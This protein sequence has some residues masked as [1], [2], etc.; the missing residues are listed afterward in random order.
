MT[1]EIP[2]FE[3]DS[4]EEKMKTWERERKGMLSDLAGKREEIRLLKEEVAEIRDA[5]T[6]AANEGDGETPQDRV[7]RLAQDP[8][9]YIDERINQFRETE[10]KPLRSELE[11]MKIDRAIERGL[12]WVAKQEKK[13]YEDVA[14]SDLEL[15][16][17][18]ITQNMKERGIVPTN[19]EEGTKEA[20]RLYLKEKE[21]KEN[22]EKERSEKIEG[23]KTESVVPP[24]RSGSHRWT[25][26]EVAAM[27]AE[28]FTKNEA[29]IRKAAA[30][31]K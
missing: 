7:N 16:L 10:V 15:D 20:Y 13:D 5:I 31:W 30:T 11:M 4:Y 23:N 14:G 28:E 22:R 19:P 25:R 2:T 27:S 12:R 21:E 8:D 18:R 1:E 24:A 9:T 3:A 26:E 29:E 6:S 17:A